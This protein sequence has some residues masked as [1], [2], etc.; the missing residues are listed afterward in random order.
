MLIYCI[1]CEKIASCD[2]KNKTCS[3]CPFETDMTCEGFKKYN[4]KV[5]FTIC[6][7]CYSI[8]R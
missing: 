7:I 5:D 2:Y 1:N 8:L 3:T 4:K 6:K